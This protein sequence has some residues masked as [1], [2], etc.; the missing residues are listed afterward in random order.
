MAY[1]YYRLIMLGLRTIEDVPD[2]EK[3]LVYGYLESEN[4]SNN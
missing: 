2:S 4:S 1:V 3:D